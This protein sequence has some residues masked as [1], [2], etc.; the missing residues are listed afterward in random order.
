MALY[1]LLKKLNYAQLGLSDYSL[2][3][4]AKLRPDLEY[5]FTIY[6]R[7]LDGLLADIGRPPEALTLVDYGGGHGFFSMYMKERGVGR[8]IYVDNNP[9]AVQTVQTVG[10]E[11]GRLPD[12]ILCGDA[13]RLRQWCEEQSLMPDGLIGLD[14][15]EHIYCLDDFFGDLFAMAPTLS[16]LF[17]TGSN[18]YSMHLTNRLHRVMRADEL[19]ND[20][21]KTGFL[22]LR[23][24]Y[25]AQHFADMDDK[26]L[27]YW[28]ANTRGLTYDDVARAVASHSPNLLRDAYNT[29]DPATGSWTERILS[30][31]EY[32]GIVQPYDSDVF[33]ENGF[34]N[35]QSRKMG[36]RMRHFLNRLLRNQAFTALAP[37]IV[38]HV[39]HVAP[40][41]DEEAAKRPRRRL[42][43]QNGGQS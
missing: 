9:L 24:Q 7:C 36:S 22:Q 12:D 35:E 28:A 13:A 33:L 15:I 11:A 18:P 39:Q 32:R 20:K 26:E 1:N 10:R 30:I 21:G 4:I 25:I 29:C 6:Q 43:R 17:T 37:F 14:V 41:E 16:I 19:G 38:L 5:Y 2:N 31:E 27:D 40:S 34:Y 3:Y 42:G 8:V 23:R